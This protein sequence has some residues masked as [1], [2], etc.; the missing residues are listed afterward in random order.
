MFKIVIDVH[1]QPLLPMPPNDSQG[2]Q[3]SLWRGVL[4]ETTSKQPVHRAKLADRTAD[5]KSIARFGP[6]HQI[7]LRLCAGCG[8]CAEVCPM[9]LI[10]IENRQ[11]AFPESKT[12]SCLRCGSCMSVCDRNAI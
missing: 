12:T 11:A 3:K 5:I 10:T 6:L 1:N 7:D 2:S 4:V 9:D 8:I